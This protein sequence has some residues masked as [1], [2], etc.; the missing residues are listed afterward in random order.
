MSFV[1]E[2]ETSFAIPISDHIIDY[3]LTTIPDV[4]N[5]T[6]YVYYFEDGSRVSQNVAQRKVIKQRNNTLYLE[7][8]FDNPI[9][10]PMMRT[11]AIEYTIDA[12]PSMM[13]AT[14]VN[15]RVILY[16]DE[17]CRIFMEFRATNTGVLN[18]IV[19]EIEYTKEVRASFDALKLKEAILFS[20]LKKFLH[21]VFQNKP[22]VISDLLNIKYMQKITMS[23]LFKF[24]CRVF[25]KF[26]K[27]YIKN[28]DIIVK[29]K[30]DGFK[31][32]IVCVEPNIVYYQDDM[33]GVKQLNSSVLNSVPNV[34][35][36]LENMCTDAA[37][38]S[39]SVPALILTDVLGVKIGKYY[40]MPDPKN[41][42]QF[43]NTIQIPMHIN[44]GDGAK[45]IIPQKVTE[46]NKKSQYPT[47]GYIVIFENREFKYKVPTFDVKVLNKRIYI[48]NINNTDVS[49]NLEICKEPDGIYEVTFKNRHESCDN[50][51]NELTF[52]RKR[53]DRTI[54][55]TQEEVNEAKQE[56][57]V[58]RKSG[59]K[60]KLSQVS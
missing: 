38:S 37:A 44:F 8:S 3:I 40:H 30:F 45:C 46:F 31:A 32:K 50:L 27:N 25:S 10:I 22:E 47:D 58:I 51:C 24:P 28:N 14:Q 53:S 18:F 7:G 1:E 35:F 13:T 59:S 42:L 60:R 19:G 39:D 48:K 16:K 20:K 54:P 11:V 26:H 52:L 36:Q 34:V 41:V 5:R 23:E 17:E 2:L 55:S 57:L 4:Q 49:L 56:F 15:A 33:F 6:T 21:S 9:I 29:H 43:F 12:P